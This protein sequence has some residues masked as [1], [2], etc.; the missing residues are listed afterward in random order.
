MEKNY[1]AKGDFVYRS[2]NPPIIAKGYGVVL[3]DNNGCK[4]LDVEA[5]NGTSSLGFDSSIFDEAMLK[6]KEV[7]SIPSFSETELRINYANKIGKK[8]SETLKIPGKVSFEIGGAQGIE[9][10]MK[11]VKK[12]TKRSQ[13]IVFEGGY[14]GRSAYSSQLS[15]SHRYRRINGDWRIPVVRIPYPDCE[16]CRF[17]KSRNNCN[18][19]CIEY[20][21][22]MFG[23]ELSGVAINDKEQDIA[24][25]VFEP[26]LNA[27]GCVIPD[28]Q[29]LEFV[30]KH[31]RDIGAL[32]VV[33]E[34]F[35]GFYRTGKFLG[36]E[37]FDISPD[38]V[39]LS[40]AIVNGCTPFSC[41]WAKDSLMTKENFAP[42]THSATYINNTFGMSVAD[43]VFDRYENWEN[44]EHDIKI[45]ETKIYKILYDI[46]N[47]FSIVKD[48]NV[49]GGFGRLLLNNNIA[50]KI[51]DIATYVSKDAP[52]D[53]YSGIILASTGL[54]P[55][56][57]AINPAL[58][59][60]DNDLN[61]LHKML[62]KT[63]E[64]YAEMYDVK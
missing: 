41:V 30:V 52:I 31:L 58:N 2:D 6:V 14:H 50:K 64:K 17:D 12:N 1:L 15:A 42:G 4:Y 60:S 34:I 32:I 49:I 53:G 45:L 25:F 11:I 33:D 8:I 51:L 39:V 13:F 63:F 22:K 37:H 5:A 16:Q 28:K 48:V 36:I 47:K 56:V 54:T 9:L 55:N 62:I 35:T 40:K 3:E 29:Y 21:K 59:I 26:I 38:I 46:K 43:T 27:G 44:C 7:P 57:V 24:A 18:H 19:E 20:F 10:A 23:S 61:L